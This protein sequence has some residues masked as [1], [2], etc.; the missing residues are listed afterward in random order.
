MNISA[1]SSLKSPIENKKIHSGRWDQIKQLA[2]DPRTV[3]GIAVAAF[4]ISFFSFFKGAEPRCSNS[5][6]L[7]SDLKLEALSKIVEQQGRNIQQ[8][9]ATL[10][11]THSTLSE[12]ST[13]QINNILEIVSMQGQSLNSTLATFQRVVSDKP[14]NLTSLQTELREQRAQLNEIAMQIQ[15]LGDRQPIS[16][17]SDVSWSHHSIQ[18]LLTLV[19]KCFDSWI[20]WAIVIPRLYSSQI[21]SCLFTPHM[22]FF[23]RAISPLA[24]VGSMLKMWLESKIPPP[25]AM[26]PVV[27]LNSFA[28][29]W[30]KMPH[31]KVLLTDFYR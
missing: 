11:M 26:T 24:E 31:N 3:T 20:C 7:G 14:E 19:Q 5:V 10:A 25:P 22:Q 29:P 30:D 15:N 27:N 23:N 12:S 2:K 1:A 13:K 8:V 21:G 28:V 9:L 6:H 17:V 16:I 4:A 18:I